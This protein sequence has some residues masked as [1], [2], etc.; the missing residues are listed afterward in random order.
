VAPEWRLVR[1]LQN[2]A[3]LRRSWDDPDFPLHRKRSTLLAYIEQIRIH[4]AV[5][6]YNVFSADRIELVWR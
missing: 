5:R 1:P 6:P 3:E 4:P 2:A